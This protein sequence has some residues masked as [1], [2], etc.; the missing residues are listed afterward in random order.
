MN[1]VRSLD[2]LYYPSCPVVA[3]PDRAKRCRI[4]CAGPNRAA[5]RNRRISPARLVRPGNPSF[6]FLMEPGL[7]ISCGAFKTR[8]KLHGFIDPEAPT[9][10]ET[11]RKPR[12]ASSSF[13]YPAVPCGGSGKVS[14]PSSARPVPSPSNISDGRW[15][16]R[17]R[18]TSGPEE[19][20]PSCRI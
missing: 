4:L 3:A 16:L 2:R 9:A 12:M 11:F 20:P 6:L 19:T 15:P 5:S 18:T 7:L 17:W 10:T 8:I 1:A 13:R 14:F